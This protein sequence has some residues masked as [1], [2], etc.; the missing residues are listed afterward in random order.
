MIKETINCQ[1]LRSVE[2]MPNT[3]YSRSACLEGDFKPKFC[4]QSGLDNRLQH[5]T[6]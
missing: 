2:C 4:K 1:I 6:H 5:K 3:P